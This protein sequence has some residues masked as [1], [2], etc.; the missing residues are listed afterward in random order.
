MSVRKS[1]EGE[2]YL[3][4]KSLKSMVGTISY[5]DFEFETQDTYSD[6]A[7][8]E[9]I[10]KTGKVKELCVAAIQTSVIGFGNKTFGRFKIKGNEIDVKELYESCDVKWNLKQNAKLSPEDLTPR[11]LQRFFRLHIH[12]YIEQHTNIMPYLWKKYS[13]HNNK[14][15][16]I[17]F[18]GS[19]SYIEDKEAALYLMKTYEYLDKRLNTNIS[20]RVLRVFA[21][22]GVLSA[23]DLQ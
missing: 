8:W 5:Q 23:S 7:V 9:A 15:R 11:R 6:T 3:D 1:G 21:T 4:K 10:K 16:S 22:R 13:D 17:T 20:E 18:P 2:Q 14:Y 12:E 19:E